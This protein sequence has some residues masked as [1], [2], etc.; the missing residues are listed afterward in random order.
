MTHTEACHVFERCIKMAKEVQGEAEPEKILE[1][2]K[3]IYE[4]I[5]H[6]QIPGRISQ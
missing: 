2:A 6:E 5:V 3:W 4:L 1:T